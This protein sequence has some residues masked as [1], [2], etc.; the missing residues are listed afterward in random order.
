M[1]RMKEWMGLSDHFGKTYKVFTQDQ[2][3]PS[4]VL[5]TFEMTITGPF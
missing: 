5:S 2:P 1:K 3:T 4:T